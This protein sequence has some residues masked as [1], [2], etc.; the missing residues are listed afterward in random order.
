MSADLGKCLAEYKRSAA[1]YAKII[2]LML[3]SF[4]VACGMM[5]LGVFS[6]DSN[7]GGRVI[8][9]IFGLFF[10]LPAVLGVYGLM[11]GRK[12]AVRLHE[13]GIAICNE[14]TETL[15]AYDD[16]AE[17]SGGPSLVITAKDDASAEFSLDGAGGAADLMARLRDEIVVKRLVPDLRKTIATGD[18][19]AFG[20]GELMGP[21]RADADATEVSGFTIDAKGVKLGDSDRQIAWSEIVTWGTEERNS[22]EAQLTLVSTWVFLKTIDQTFRASIEPLSDREALLALGNEMISSKP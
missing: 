21:E 4:A 13:H 18:L 19:I 6:G 8:M 16:I 15:F 14:E 5:G 20:C 7:I 3:G 17:Y 10:T 1:R 2:A 12:N 9:F 22:R 11:K